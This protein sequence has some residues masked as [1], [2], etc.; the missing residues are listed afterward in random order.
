MCAVAIL[1]AVSWLSSCDDPK[2]FPR[3]PSESVKVS[4]RDAALSA[5]DVVPITSSISKRA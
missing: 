2:D 5:G 1:R 4:A 3:R